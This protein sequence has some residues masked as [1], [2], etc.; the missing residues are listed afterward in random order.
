MRLKAGR[1]Y[2]MISSILREKDCQPRI[3][4]LAK[5]SFKN[6]SRINTF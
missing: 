6:V 1:Q 4:Y 2:G 5:M 3:P